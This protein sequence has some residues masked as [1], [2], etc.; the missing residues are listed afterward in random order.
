MN[1]SIIFILFTLIS[2]W[3]FSQ[4]IKKESIDSGGGI[5]T[6]DGIV[7][8]HTIG[9]TLVAEKSEATLKV[10]E[11]F[12]SPGLLES[13]GVQDFTKL[14]GVTAYPNPTT[15]FLNIDFP[16][17]ENYSIQVYDLLGKEIKEVS[18]DGETYTLNLSELESATYL[19]VVKNLDTKQ[20]ATYKILKK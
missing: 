9:E 17:T 11:G 16:N 1:K 18:T 6:G 10:S 13:I 15:D 2:L 5:A 8:I 14:E 20:Y 4:E 3:A 19:V 7:A 12:I